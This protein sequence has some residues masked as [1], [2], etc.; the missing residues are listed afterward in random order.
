MSWNI[1]LLIFLSVTISAVAQ[2]ALKHGMSTASV[3]QAL[4]QGGADALYGVAKSLFV[5]LGLALYGFGAL[6]WLGVLAR[7]DVSQAYPFVGLGFLLTMLF[8]VFLL[9][10]AFSM[11]RALGTLLVLAGVFLV[12]KT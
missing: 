12:A 6:L 1:L 5:W 10:E 7:V 8:G 2:I 4:M 3:Q 11:M 9:G